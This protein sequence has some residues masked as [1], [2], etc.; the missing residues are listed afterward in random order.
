VSREHFL[1]ERRNAG[2][3]LVDGES[4]CGT[5]IVGTS[6]SPYVFKFRIG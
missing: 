4:T 5:I 2:C 1:I 3:V 6:L